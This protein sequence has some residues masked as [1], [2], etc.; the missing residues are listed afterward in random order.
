MQLLQNGKQQFFD[1]NGAPLA[2][3]SVYFYAPGTTNPVPTY[4]DPNGATLNTNPIQLDSRGQAI[5][6]G[7]GTFRQVLKDAAGNTLWDQLV[8]DSSAGLLGNIS[9][10]TF[11]AGTDF[12][13]GVTASLTL[14]VPPLSANNLWVFFDGAF[15]DD[16]QSSLSGS[17]LT[18]SSPIP[19][20]VT[21]VTVKIGA[22]VS[23]GTPS[24]GAVYNSTVASNA[25]IDGAKL[26]YRHGAAS[27]VAR[28]V[29][30]KFQ[31]VVSVK[32]FGAKGDGATDDTTAITAADTYAISVGARL[33]FPAG[34]YMAS[35]LVVNSGSYW[36]G[37]RPGT[38][39]K[40]I[41]GSNKDFIYGANSTA[42]WGQA[43]P[44]TYVNGYT[45]ER[46]II[47]G[48]WNAGAGNTAGNGVVIFGAG[49]VIRDVYIRNVFGHALRTE[50]PP[51]GG[52]WNT[53]TVEGCFENIKIDTCGQRGWWFNGPNDSVV[54]N[55]IVVDAGQSASNTYDAF[56]FDSNG[57][58]RCT[59]LHGWNRQNSARHQFV[60]NLQPGSQS[61]FIDCQFEGGYAANV[62]I[63]SQ[64]NI[65]SDSCRYFAAW[66][67]VNIYMGRTA[68]LNV[69]R[70]VL[71]GPSAGR[72]VV[73]GIIMGSAAGDYIADNDID[74][75]FIAQENNIIAFTNYNG[76]NN[77]VRGNCYNATS[78]S[79]VGVPNANDDVDLAIHNAGGTSHVN[80]RRQTTSQ[81]VNASASVTWTFPYP[82][83]A[84][85]SVKWSPRG[86]SGNITS[87]IWITALSATSVTIFNNNGVSMTLDIE[88]SATN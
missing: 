7:T 57:I 15:Q 6:W 50:Y 84:N 75:K 10:N 38:V 81:T 8:K 60:L 49:P 27:S 65:F 25:A 52:A 79:I 3:G 48:N 18:F 55:V 42:N 56:Y 86:P 9:D 34:T 76:G 16:S 62:G 5:I 28:T 41:V 72:P 30:N 51:S 83:S 22:T 23:V 70:G 85:P 32:D 88:A 14:S 63:F 31:D 58:A 82:F 71:D 17:T 40:Q 35:Q 74:C 73:S 46:L 20:G 4:Q 19:V 44:A 26:S 11:V 77:R 43:D 80:N 61:E 69:I 1:Q 66:N 33:Y 45:L 12:T 87:G 53:S 78:A 47:D 37:D 54:H 13:P 24:D 29:K 2:N 39:L 67:G 21:K 36:T 64:R 59:G 68:T